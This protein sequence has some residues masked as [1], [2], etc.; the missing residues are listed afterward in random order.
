METTKAGID[1][2]ALLEDEWYMV[3]HS[4][5]IP[6]VALHSALH[7]LSEDPGGPGIVLSPG[8]RARLLDGASQRYLEI[9]LRDLLPQ[10]MNTSAYRGIKRSYVNWQRFLLFCERH[11]LDEAAHRQIVATR[12]SEVLNR[13]LVTA[14]GEKKSRMFN[15]SFEELAAFMQLLGLDPAGFPSLSSCCAT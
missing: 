10:N 4:G 7:H 9:T 8:Q 2:E 6:E 13:E 5:E 1:I 12:L 14:E 15:C 3:R 11:Q